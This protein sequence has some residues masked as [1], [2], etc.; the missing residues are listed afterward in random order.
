MV[1]VPVTGSRKRRCEYEDDNLGVESEPGS[2]RSYPPFS[3]T[4][5][6]N[7]DYLRPIAMPKA[8]KKPVLE[9]PGLIESEMI[10]VGDFG[11]AGFFRP[12]EWGED[13]V[14]RM[15][16]ERGERVFW[17]SKKNKG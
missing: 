2:P 12:D 10:D 13:W 5:M 17:N 4:R 3:Y 9:S 6:P 16:D 14:M 7:L 1:D 11:E 8:R 15:R